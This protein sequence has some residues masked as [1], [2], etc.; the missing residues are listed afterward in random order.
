V[1][2]I[3]D[4]GHQDEIAKV[5]TVANQLEVYSAVLAYVAEL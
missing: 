2:Q 4:G 5:T 3:F 1:Q